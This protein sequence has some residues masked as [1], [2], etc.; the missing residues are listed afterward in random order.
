MKD[1]RYQC[2]VCHAD[3]RILNT[4]SYSIHYIIT[5]NEKLEQDKKTEHCNRSVYCS[6]DTTHEIPTNLRD[7]LADE[8]EST[9]K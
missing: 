1:M 6:N 8:F 3:L 2:P 9:F 7:K 4:G 5:D